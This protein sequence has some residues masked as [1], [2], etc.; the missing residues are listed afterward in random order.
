MLYGPGDKITLLPKLKPG[1]KYFMLN[2]DGTCV[3]KKHFDYVMPEMLKYSGQTVVIK[4]AC[5]YGYTVEGDAN[6]WCWTDEM[7]DNK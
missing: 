6:S 5:T 2:P 1:K 3:G 4:T 7:F